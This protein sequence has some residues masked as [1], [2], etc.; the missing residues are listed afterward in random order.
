MLS[1][2]TYEKIDDDGLHIIHDNEP[3]VLPVDSIIICAGQTEENSLFEPLKQ[4]G[5]TV[6]VIGGAHKA[7]ELDARNAIYQAYALGLKI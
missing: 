5:Q 7:L 4:L 6:H 1:G 3:C 2:V